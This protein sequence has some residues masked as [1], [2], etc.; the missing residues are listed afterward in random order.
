M[1]A[2]PPTHLVVGSE[3]AVRWRPTEA[4][5]VLIGTTGPAG[6]FD[7]TFLTVPAVDRVMAALADI[8]DALNTP[9]TTRRVPEGSG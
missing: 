6:R 1:T 2:H 5:L 4:R 9:A 3:T 7:L 8:R